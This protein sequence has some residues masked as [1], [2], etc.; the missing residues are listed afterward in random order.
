M[1]RK[2]KYPLGIAFGGGGARG[3]YHLGVLKR[4]LEMGHIPQIVSGTSV[5]AIVAAYY[6]QGFTVEE[7]LQAFEHL[8]L[9]DFLW[10]K[11]SKEY[12]VDS[13]PLR[14]IF[15]ETFRV[16]TFEELKVPVKIVATCLETAKEV[17][18]ESGPLAEAVLASCSIPVLFPP[19]EINGK[20]YVDGGV[21]RNIP[22]TPIR[23]S[24][25][26]VYAINLFPEQGT[27][28]A[29]NKS[30]R[31]IA[32]RSISMLFRAGAKADLQRADLVIEN[33]GMARFNAFDL[34]YKDEMYEL[35]Y[36]TVF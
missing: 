10:Q 28:L 12:L 16:Q 29:Y 13:K 34:K 25:K 9:K 15:E 30:I 18:F 5:G 1:I 23:N 2:R 31:H 36:N 8:T 11:L 21:M 27:D 7:I 14:K 32:D 20:H 24:C 19:A 33:K 35:G 6:A 17:V 3:Y 26:R 22:V 4:L